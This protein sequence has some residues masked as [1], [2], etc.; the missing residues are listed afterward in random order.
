MAL[1]VP[2][3][4]SLPVA[5]GSLVLAVGFY[6]ATVWVADE[7]GRGSAQVRAE[8]NNAQPVSFTEMQPSLS[9]QQQPWAS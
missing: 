3:P 5:F 9:E 1:E 7:V 8:A 4:A 6:H 2:V